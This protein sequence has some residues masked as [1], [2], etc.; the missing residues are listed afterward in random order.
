MLL[1]K[2]IKFFTNVDFLK[3]YLRIYLNV[4]HLPNYVF[5]L[6]RISQYQVG[7]IVEMEVANLK[8]DQTKRVY[9][10]TYGCQMNVTDSEIV[11]AILQQQGY[12]V[13]EEINEADLILVNTC[14]IRE[15]AE[16]R[17]RGRIDVFRQVK[18]KNKN[19]VV[20]V[21][22]CMAERL[23]DQL[24][25]EEKA[26]DLVVGPDAYRD[27]PTLLNGIQPGQKAV[28]TLLSTE[29]TYADVSPVR[30]DKNNVSAF[31]AIMRGCNNFCSYCVVPYTR[32]R[33]RSR[34]PETILREVKELV[35]N[36]YKE[37]TLLGQNVNS[38]NWEGLSFPELLKKVAEVSPILRVRFATSH[39]KDLSDEL[40]DAIAGAK[41]I[42]KHVHLPVQSGS[43]RMLEKMNRKYTRE[44]YINR[45]QAI[46]N[47]IPECAITTDIIAGFCDETEDDH[48]ETISLMKIAKYSSAY[49]FKYSER[50]DTYA[51]NNYKDNIPEEIKTRR[52]N[53]IIKLQNELSLQSN[54]NEIGKEFEV[55][56][57]GFSKKS[58]EQLFGRNSQ[59]KV[60]VFPALNAKV[61]DYVKVK[62][63][64][65]TSATL[66]GNQ[67]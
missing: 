42:C 54:R 22:G 32:G 15:N 65:C 57:E 11:V 30:M 52:L 47:K 49:M 4:Y 18:K 53:E 28:N 3:M 64:K 5:T 40:I 66:I 14:S 44:W 39:P 29:E 41:N 20:G 58:R 61:G 7:K 26:V 13:T 46:L 67:V 21:I 17:I 43:T 48:K 1:I 45:L 16:K 59:N 34:N 51:A 19:A 60:I 55:L 24:L 27:L 31:V 63:E 23:K 9:I 8:L 35:S 38:Y 12:R 6:H 10:E 37:V 62:V 50:P 56:V 25:D 36:G 2:L 33:E